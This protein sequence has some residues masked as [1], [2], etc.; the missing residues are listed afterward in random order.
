[1][2]IERSIQPPLQNADRANLVER[3]IRLVGDQHITVDD[4]FKIRQLRIATDQDGEEYVAINQQQEKQ[5]F[6]SLL[7]KPACRLADVVRA[8][9]VSSDE[10]SFQ[11]YSHMINLDTIE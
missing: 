10:G 4:G 2:N 1:M 8:A 6:V 7:M 11:Y 5:R 9:D 3:S